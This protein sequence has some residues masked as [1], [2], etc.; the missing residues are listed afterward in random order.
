MNARLGAALV[1]VGVMSVSVAARIGQPPNTALYACVDNTESEATLVGATLCT[2][3]PTEVL[4]ARAETDNLQVRGGALVAEVDR[5]G[6]AAV[7]GLSAGDL[8]YR[9]GGVDVDEAA[10]ATERL[11]AIHA[12]ADTVVNFLRGGRPYRVKLRR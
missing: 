7:A 9:V 6:I 4:T 5:A 1:F 10:A 3:E 11:G 8:I 12:D 2:G